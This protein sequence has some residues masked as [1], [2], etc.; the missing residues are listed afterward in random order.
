MIAARLVC[1]S[2]SKDDDILRLGFG[3]RSLA[4]SR[5]FTSS[6]NRLNKLPGWDKNSWGYHG[7]DGCSFSAEKAGNAYGETFGG[8]PDPGRPLSHTQ[9]RAH[10]SFTLTG[11]DIVGAGIDFSQNRAFFT[12]N[13]N[14][15][16]EPSSLCRVW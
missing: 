15:I 5:S 6:D 4:R 11:G 7:D 3:R 14:L 9:E 16:G 8:D 12:K 10:P 2:D 13:G 1:S